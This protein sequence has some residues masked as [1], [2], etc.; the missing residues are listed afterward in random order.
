MKAPI[1]QRM[2]SKL[3]SMALASLLK[4]FGFP[5]QVPQVLSHPM[6][7]PQSLLAYLPSPLCLANSNS[8]FQEPAQISAP[9]SPQSTNAD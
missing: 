4:S 3:L 5:H 6:N 9:V 7:M 2:K 8:V 1:V